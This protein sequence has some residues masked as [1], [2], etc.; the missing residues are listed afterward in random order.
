MRPIRARAACIRRCYEDA[1]ARNPAIA[2]RVSVRFVVAEDGW[3][4]RAR[5]ERDE[6]GDS[7]FAE[8]VARQL[9]G[10]AYPAPD[11]GP[12]TVIYPFTFSP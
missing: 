6:T 2:G 9:V 5:V 1:L 11:G 8:C 7:A 4:R 3:V 12:V 10:L